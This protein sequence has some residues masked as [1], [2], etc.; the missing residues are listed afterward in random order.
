MHDELEDDRAG[1]DSHY[2]IHMT[3]GVSAKY[4][5]KTTPD[6]NVSGWNQQ[7]KWHAG[8]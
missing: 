4:S 1:E 3:E 7:I 2:I 5:Y 8:W 6:T